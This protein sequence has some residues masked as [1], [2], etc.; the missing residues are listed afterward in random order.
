MCLLSEYRPV[1]DLMPVRYDSSLPGDNRHEEAGRKL[2]GLTMDAVS[3][4]GDLLR[5]SA[6]VT[7]VL[8]PNDT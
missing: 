8:P 5:R 6:S 3:L 2:A 1:R 4:L 7:G